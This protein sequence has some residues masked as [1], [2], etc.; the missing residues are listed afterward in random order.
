MFI[1][2]N[3]FVKLLL[4]IRRRIEKEEENYSLNRV[5]VTLKCKRLSRSIRVKTV[6]RN[7]FNRTL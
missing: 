5:F 1:C 3:I 2:N 7:K 4:I 6:N